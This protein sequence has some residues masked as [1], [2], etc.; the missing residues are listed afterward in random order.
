MALHFP[1]WGTFRGY[2]SP[3]PLLNQVFLRR[4][5]DLNLRAGISRFAG[6]R[7]RCITTLPTLHNK[8]Y[9]SNFIFKLQQHL[10]KYILKIL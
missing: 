1:L 8:E 6:F 2:N 4:V 9:Y 10:K 7:V 3:N 5:Q